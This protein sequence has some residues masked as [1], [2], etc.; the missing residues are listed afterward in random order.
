MRWRTSTSNQRH[1][2]ERGGWADQLDIWMVGDHGHAPVSRHED[3]HGWLEQRGLRVR[4]H[5]Q[6]F[7]R[8]VD[9]ALMVGGNAMAHI[10]L[11]PAARTRAW[12]PAHAPR[13][14][15]L[16]DALVA[17]PAIDLA[18]VATAATTVEV[19]HATRGTAELR[20]TLVGDEPHF[21][22]DARNGD[23]LQLGGSF[24]ALSDRDAWTLCATSPYPDA[25]VQLLTLCTAGRAG[26][27]VLSAADGWDL[28]ARFEPVAHV[29]THGALL[30]DQMLVPLLLDAP[31]SGTPQRTADVMPSALAALGLPVPHGLDG[32]S[33]W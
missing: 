15:Q 7:Q 12:W 11:E 30:R 22:Y 27:I 10:Y 6:I 32:R 33:F 2:R 31:I 20:V 16:H 21:D 29:S 28:R 4:A 13:W 1:E 14:T 25:I 17:R 5:P 3:L 18:A 8:T 19:S 26:D 24:M 23:A 9:V